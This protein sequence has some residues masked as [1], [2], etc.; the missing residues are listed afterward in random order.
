MLKLIAMS[1]TYRQAS[2]ETSA[3]HD[4]DPLNQ[5]FARQSK[6]RF[7]AEVVRD[8]A[9]SIS[10]L[11]VDRLDGPSVKPYQPAGYYRH[12]NFPEREYQS[13]TD[14]RQWRRGVYMHWQRQ[15][16]HPMLK[17]F[18][19]PSREECTAQRPRSN[20]P[21]AALVLLNDPSF[22][23]AAR[24]FAARILHEAV[25]ASGKSPDAS[26]QINFAFRCAIS[27]TANAEEQKLLQNLLDQSR[28][29][30]ADHRDE[31]DKLLAI[32]FKRVPDDLDRIELASWT[33]VA[34]SI[35]SMNEV[36]T[37]N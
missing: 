7:P 20:T 37:R 22:V 28:H 8:S 34:R 24:I 21:L 23:E 14:D 29:Y 9:L 6:F 32:G 10:G 26:L 5:F 12:L 11:L 33:I 15:F 16:L 17:A 25:A 18:D 35:L 13:D 36:L 19:A 4:R 30:Y 1:R 27:R 3:L 2:V 31:A